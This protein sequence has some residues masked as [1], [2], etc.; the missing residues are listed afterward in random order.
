MKNKLVISLYILALAGFTFL[1]TRCVGASSYSEGVL[2]YDISFP[3]FNEEEHPI[4]AV[5]LPKKQI[6]SFS[7][8]KMHSLIKK[9][10]FEL[11]VLTDSDEESFYSDF[12]FNDR[13]FFEG[14]GSELKKLLTNGSSYSITYS[15]KTDTLLGFTIHH[16][17]AKSNDLT[18]F[19]LW[20]TKD[21]TMKNPNW[22]NP[23]HEIPGMLLRY[24][25][26]Q[27][28][29]KMKFE[30]TKFTP[31]KPAVELFSPAREG[32]QLDYSQYNKQLSELFDN[33]LK[34]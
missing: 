5:F 22:F 17:V 6:V 8:N 15:E 14:E 30:A 21:I 4:I 20:Y 31:E 26:L 18:E 2:E 29:V 34:S 16:A 28:G 13:K 3:D 12:L 24:T 25:I 27:N 23:Y 33:L 11:T 1:V 10:V 7:G 19:E 32:N 9:A